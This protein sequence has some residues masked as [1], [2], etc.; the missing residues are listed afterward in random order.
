[1]ICETYTQPIPK[2]KIS[3]TLC[4]VGTRILQSCLTGHRKT[5]I[6]LTLLK[7]AWMSITIRRFMHFASGLRTQNAL[8]GL[9]GL[10]ISQQYQRDD[11]NTPANE[12]YETYAS[13]A[14]AKEVH[15]RTINEVPAVLAWQDSKI[16]Q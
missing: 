5:T 13:N 14:V 4:N 9:R 16:S 3:L 11:R 1:M 12:D 2:T 10:E 6:S 15:H 7:T 8:I